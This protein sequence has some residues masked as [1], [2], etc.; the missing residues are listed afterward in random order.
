MY[1]NR[2]QRNPSVLLEVPKHTELE[3]VAA[4]TLRS[5]MTTKDKV[6]HQPRNLVIY[7]S[8][9]VLV[10]IRNKRQSFIISV[11]SCLVFVIIPTFKG[12]ELDIIKVVLPTDLAHK[13]T[14]DRQDGQKFQISLGSR[15]I[16]V[17]RD[18]LST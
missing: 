10:P 11:L 12:Y 2:C 16:K 8:S 18:L 4:D 17:I 9:S 6:N 3:N 5:K 15:Y 7:G 13:V 14:A 1:N